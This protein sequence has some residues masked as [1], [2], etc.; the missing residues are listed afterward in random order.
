MDVHTYRYHVDTQSK[1][2]EALNLTG[3]TLVGQDWGGLIGLRVVAENE[4]RFARVA[5]SNTA[6]PDAEP[7]SDIGPGFRAWKARNQAMVDAGDIPVGQMVSNSISDPSTRE[8]YDAP[9]PDPIYKAGPLI[10]PQRVPVTPDMPG[11]VENAAAWAVFEQWQK[12]FLTSFSDG[13]PITR[14]NERQFQA[15]IPGAHNQNHTIIEGAGH[16][17][18]EPKGEE[19]ARLII[20]FLRANPQ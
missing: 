3:V 2:I 4:E 1:L 6:L 14:G 10:M 11:A 18:Q 7:G 9:F 20:D 8:A 12:P 15:R 5:I 19:W 17:I 13:D 16:F